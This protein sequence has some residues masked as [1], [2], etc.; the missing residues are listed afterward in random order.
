MA[1]GVTSPSVARAGH[2]TGSRIV[3]L[4]GLRAIAILLVLGCHYPGFANHLWRIPEFG[5]IGVD[6][7][8]ALSGYLI[9][10]I[11]LGL[12]SRPTPYRTFYSRRL[13]R[14]LPP[15]L[16]V[17]FFLFAVAIVQ[18]W[19]LLN[20]AISQIFFL[21]AFQ[22]L[23]RDFLR[24]LIHHPKFYLTHLP[25]LL[26]YAHNLRPAQ[27]GVEMICAN[28]PGTYWSLSIEE[29]FYLLWAPIVLRCSRRTILRI[30]LGVCAAEMF[31][32]WMAGYIAYFSLLS[33]FDALLY[34]ALL[35]LL[36]ERWRDRGTP[37]WSG[38]FFAMIV[39]CSSAAIAGILCAIRPILGREI[40]VSPLF[41]VIGLSL[42]SIAVAGL[43]GLLLRN[44]GNSWWLGRLLRSRVLVFLGTISYTMYLAHISAG[45]AV[46]NLLTLAVLRIPPI[47]EAI[48]ATILTI[49]ISYASWHWLEK[50]LL[51]WKDRRFPNAPHPPEPRLS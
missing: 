8:F 45:A 16:V 30:V 31:V 3:E 51:R 11:L 28:A 4:D 43:V 19:K 5:W 35:A 48:F 34:G 17:T 41:L 38:R 27:A 14:I 32:R 10:T 6:I 42:F 47:I 46:H 22:D 18:H 40:R 24:Q 13:I 15:Y 21:Q 44:A 26:Q 25:P 37:P 50:P 12:R 39:T 7:F 20:L 29:Y 9:T 23:T 1:S 2:G 36:L 33:R 49:L